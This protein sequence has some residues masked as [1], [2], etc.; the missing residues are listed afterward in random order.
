MS[1]TWPWGAILG[2]LVWCDLRR[3]SVSELAAS[4]VAS[5]RREVEALRRLLEDLEQAAGDRDSSRWWL[6][7]CF[8]ALVVTWI[9]AAVVL[10][11]SWV[12]KSPSLSLPAITLEPVAT[13]P[14]DLDTPSSRTSTSASNFP[15]ARPVRPSDLRLR[16]KAS[17]GGSDPGHS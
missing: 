13:A 8:R 3:P 7:V 10:C 16:A 17:D 14:S 12:K 1:S 15:K 2:Y 9:L 5:L 4:E 11:L 6:H